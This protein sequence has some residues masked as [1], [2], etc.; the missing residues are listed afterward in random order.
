M[1][2]SRLP[3]ITV[4]CR[5]SHSF[6][7]RAHGGQGVDCP[8]CR[9]GGER[10]KVWIRKDRPRNARELA[11]QAAEDAPAG[12]AATAVPVGPDPEL[13]ARWAQEAPWD[14][15]LRF[16]PGRPGDECGKCG[17]RVQ[18]EPGRTLIYCPACKRAGLPAAVTAHYARQAQRSTEVASRAAPDAAAERAARVR[19]RALAQRMTDRLGEWLDAFDPDDLTGNPERA[20][21]DYRAELSA[22]LPEIR[23]AGS[24]R[25]LADIMQEITGVIE[26]A[27]RSGALASIEQQRG[28]IERQA[29]QAERAAE[30]A[31]AERQR[32][33]QERAE[34][35]RTERA[36][37]QAAI[38]ART[39]RRAIEGQAGH[40]TMPGYQVINA[41]PGQNGY[42]TATIGIA[43]MIE[44]NRAEKERKL[45][46]Y[47]PCGYGDEHRKPEVPKRRYWIMTLDWQGSESGYAVPGAPQAV[48]CKKHFAMA[49]VW[50]E[51]QAAAIAARGN[52]LIKAVY[53]ELT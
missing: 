44:R 17:E 6:Q 46:E 48:V 39:E 11:D 52:P 40:R 35:E 7:T 4:T 37:R 10:V 19:L 29:E 38:A 25:E 3:E 1:T 5:N 50:I 18:W 41:R 15:K 13:V 28:A 32:A 53:T 26:R 22:Y 51:E 31:E 36:E 45:A 49:D 16:L 33:A 47:G 20:A 24:E 42:V 2:T 34:L 23:A 9:A 30:W 27:E 8:Q 14:G 12:R 43:G 21:R